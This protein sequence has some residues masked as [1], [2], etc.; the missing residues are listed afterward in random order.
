[1]LYQIITQAAVKRRPRGVRRETSPFQIK[2]ETGFSAAPEY[3]V[4]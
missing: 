4:F 3:A 2:S 1:M